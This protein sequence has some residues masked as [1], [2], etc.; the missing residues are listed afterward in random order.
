MKVNVH[1]TIDVELAQRMKTLGLSPS[2]LLTEML[3]EKFKGEL[4]ELEKS[5][6]KDD[7]KDDSLYD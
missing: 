3:E 4:K 7:K 1:L 2:K 5:K 6:V